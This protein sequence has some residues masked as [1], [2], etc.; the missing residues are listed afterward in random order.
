M[1]IARTLLRSAFQ[2]GDRRV[3]SETLDLITGKIAANEAVWTPYN[4]ALQYIESDRNPAVLTRQ[5]PEMRE[6]ATLLIGDFD[7]A[8]PVGREK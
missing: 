3:I 5:H 8:Q 4:V 6:A 2:T 7:D 1:Y